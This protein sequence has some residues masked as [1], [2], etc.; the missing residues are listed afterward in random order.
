MSINSSKA[1][2]CPSCGQLQEITVW[3]SITVKD[4]P[5]LKADLLSGRVNIFKCG[6]CSHS[7]LVPAP[8]L[9]HDEDKKLMISFSPCDDEQLKQRLFENVRE[10][11]KGSGELSG[12]SGYNLR[13]VCEYNSLLEKILIFDAGLNDKAVEIIKLLILSQEPEKQDDRFCVFGKKEEDSIEFMVRDIKENM[14][15]TSRAPI[16]TYDTIWQQLRA[17]GVKP[18]SFDWEMVDAVYADRLI[19][20]IN[21]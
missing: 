15:Y 10:T 14:I 6:S 16:S 8:L 5:D 18:Y 12:Y 2:R 17:S 11:S 13:F 21:N 3:N 7:G 19:K 1:I 4:S 20:G 9:Y